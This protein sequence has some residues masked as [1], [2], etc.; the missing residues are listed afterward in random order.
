MYVAFYQQFQAVGSLLWLQSGLHLMAA[1]SRVRC[2]VA[3][4][5][6]WFLERDIE[7]TVLKWLPQSPELSLTEHLWDVVKHDIH[8]M[9]VQPKNLQ[10]LC[11]AIE[12]I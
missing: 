2:H 12:P 10:Q 9:D 3:K 11:E 5:S 6:N 4:P 7:V 8:I 1:S